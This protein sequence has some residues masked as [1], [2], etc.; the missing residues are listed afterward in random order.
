MLKFIDF[1]VLRVIIEHLK[2][3]GKSPLQRQLWKPGGGLVNEWL[4]S[5]GV[6][7]HGR[8]F[9]DPMTGNRR[10]SYSIKRLREGGY[11][12][13]TRYLPTH[14]GKLLNTRIGVDWCSWPDGT[15]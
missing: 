15:S 2:A 13:S 1:V 4:N 9:A 11:L 14:K 6:L 7:S 10:L 5:S 8:K 3:H 12:N